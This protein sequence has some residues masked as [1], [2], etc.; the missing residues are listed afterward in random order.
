MDPLKKK[1]FEETLYYKERYLHIRGNYNDFDIE[2]AVAHGKFVVLYAIIEE[3]GLDAE[4]QEWKK[5][6]IPHEVE[7]KDPVNE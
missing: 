2:V 4:F 5:G 1:L 7:G 3:M 6:G